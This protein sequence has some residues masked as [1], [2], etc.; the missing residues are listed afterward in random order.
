MIPNLITIAALRSVLSKPHITYIF[1]AE[2]SMYYF[3][4]FFFFFLLF[5]FPLHSKVR[6]G[7]YGSPTGGHVPLL[8]GRM[9]CPGQCYSSGGLGPC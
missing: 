8:L 6:T 5:F 2:H 4:P 3:F 7:T 9:P 1:S